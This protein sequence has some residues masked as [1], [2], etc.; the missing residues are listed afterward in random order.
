MSNYFMT[1]TKVLRIMSWVVFTVSM[2]L[3][4]SV[5]WKIAVGVLLFGWAMNIENFNI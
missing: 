4:W 1:K 5:N 2:I 3:L